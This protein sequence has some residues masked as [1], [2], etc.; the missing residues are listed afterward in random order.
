M[1]VVEV[2]IPTQRRPCR[3]EAAATDR[4]PLGLP[5][6]LQIVVVFR[7]FPAT[8]LAAD[9]ARSNDEVRQAF[10]AGLLDFKNVLKDFTGSNSTAWTL[11]AQ[12]VGAVV[13]ARAMF[14]ESVQRELVSAVRDSVAELV[15][16]PPIP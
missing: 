8:S 1:A 16:K 6:Q 12:N 13:I 7:I 11:I 10:E 5:C 2:Q 3:I 15:S 9:V 4:Q 14:N